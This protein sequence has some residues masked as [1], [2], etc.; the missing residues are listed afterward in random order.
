MS[1]IV[2]RKSLR[3]VVGGVGLNGVGIDCLI[4]KGFCMM[5]IVFFGLGI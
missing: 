1:L 5:C 3:K 4:W 2:S